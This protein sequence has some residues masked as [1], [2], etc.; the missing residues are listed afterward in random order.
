MQTAR[1]TASPAAA[2]GS[3]SSSN[4]AATMPQATAPNVTRSGSRNFLASTSAPA[5][6]NAPNTLDATAAGQGNDSEETRPMATVPPSRTAGFG[7]RSSSDA[8]VSPASR[9]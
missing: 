8:G 5:S 2:H 6:I 1:T 4:G 7:V 9:S 3:T